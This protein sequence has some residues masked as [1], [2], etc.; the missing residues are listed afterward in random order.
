MRLIIAFVAAVLTP[1]LALVGWY[2]YGQFAMFDSNDP[3]IWVR[4]REFFVI[5][6]VIS[7]AH[8]IALGIPTYFLLRWRRL[9]RWWS[10]LFA[11][12]VLGAV[13]VGAFSWPLHSSPGSYALANGVQTIIN[14]VPTMAGW[15]QYFGGV[16]FFGVC[17][18]TAAAAFVSCAA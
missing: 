3:Y 7:A 13:P 14:G 12:F 15:L 9:I 16:L 18:L 6:F 11:G 5:C 2:I 1:T 4:T 8:V 10:V 17:G